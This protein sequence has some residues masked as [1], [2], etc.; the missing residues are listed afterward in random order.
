[1]RRLRGRLDSGL[2]KPIFA[3]ADF[4]A[5]TEHQEMDKQIGLYTFGN[6]TLGRR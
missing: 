5:E 4:C 3:R 1:M 6:R 2:T